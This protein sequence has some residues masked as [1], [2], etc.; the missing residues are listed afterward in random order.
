MTG[1][2]GR[3][4]RGAFAGK[5]KQKPRTRSRRAVIAGVLALLVSALL[6]Q[7]P[8]LSFEAFSPAFAAGKAKGKDKDKNKD[9]GGGSDTGNSGGGN[10]NAG[11]NGNGNV[12]EKQKGGSDNGNGVDNGITD[13]NG[14]AI[15][16]GDGVGMGIGVGN[17]DTIGV[18]IGMNVGDDKG[19]HRSLESTDRDHGAPRKE[20]WDRDDWSPGKDTEKRHKNNEVDDL[21]LGKQFGVES[22]QKGLG[23]DLNE[24]GKLLTD[25]DLQNGL[26]GA[27]HRPAIDDQPATEKLELGNAKPN[28]K[29]DRSDE[30]ENP[31]KADASGNGKMSGQDKEKNADKTDA[32]AEKSLAKAE[33]K[34]EKQAEK[35]AKKAAKEA[36]KEAKKNN[37]DQDEETAETAD[38][39]ARDRNNAGGSSS[40]VASPGTYVEREVLGIGLSSASISRA[41]QL[42]FSISET[43]LE[44]EQGALLT[45]YAPTGLD[46]L[47]A[48]T[49]LRRELPRDA[50][51]LNRIYRPYNTAQDDPGGAQDPPPGQP[52]G[53]GGCVG[54]KCYGRAAI[55]WKERLAD[56]ARGTNVGVIDTDVDLRH[57]A[58]SGQKITRK[59]FL[60][61]GKQSSSNGHG[62]GVLALL[63]G[64]RHSGTPG[65]IPEAQFFFAN[66]FFTDSNGETIGDTVSL[67]KALEWM[68]GSRTKVVNMSFSGPEDELVQVRLKAMRARG[69]AFTAAA[70]NQGPAAAPS[71]PAAYPE[72]VAV[73]AVGKDM[74]V[75]P[76]AN[77]GPYVDVAAP[78]VRIWTAIPGAREAYRTGTSFAAPFATAILALQQP[79][80]LSAAEE[81]LLDRM[82]TAEL[83]PNGRD[84]IY[85]RGLLQAPE[86]CSG[87][88]APIAVSAPAM[89]AERR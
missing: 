7:L 8:T 32:K 40:A 30:T 70:G 12:K 13:G 46:S 42:G 15:D 62:T 28:A 37:K 87:H 31:A 89:R 17:D 84:P 71:Y 24:L 44:Q 60:A 39:A 38:A 74:R 55:G 4:R 86:E 11:G 65:L 43:R 66:I 22:I 54:D 45:L 6:L 76:S 75:Y 51:Y 34:A 72:V 19:K 41:R 21:D 18:G 57:P 78:G 69:V 5:K 61:D 52:G 26:A 10:G 53:D 36:A 1:E 50:F 83:G 27:D 48:I 9:N 80:S 47:R 58:F 23:P 64:G 59:T 85:G 49:L 82:K 2:G 67:L 81:E 20:K 73:T 79:D 77:R 56:C 68:E 63:A 14:L 29:A 35:E 3:L 33:K 88:N 16:L 25:G